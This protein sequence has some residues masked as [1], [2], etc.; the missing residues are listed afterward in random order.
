MKEKEKGRKDYQLHQFIFSMFFSVLCFPVSCN[1]CHIS[2][3]QLI[4][5]FSLSHDSPTLSLMEHLHTSSYFSFFPLICQFECL[6]VYVCVCLCVCFVPTIIHILYHLLFSFCVVQRA[7]QKFSQCFQARGGRQALTF[8]FLRHMKRK[9]E[10][11]AVSIR[12]RDDVAVF[13]AFQPYNP[14]SKRYTD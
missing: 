8:S 5:A 13:H 12:K 14:H 9:R 3:Q 6:S 2:Q 1:H 4:L 11:V 7:G 10:L